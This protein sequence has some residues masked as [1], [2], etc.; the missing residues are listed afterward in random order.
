MCCTV[1]VRGVCQGIHSNHYPNCIP[2]SH[3][4][5]TCV[6]AMCVWGGGG[7]VAVVVVGWQVCAVEG[8]MLLKGVSPIIAKQLTLFSSISS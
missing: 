7:G 8:G 1:C 5:C 2:T 4:Y 3:H 6:R